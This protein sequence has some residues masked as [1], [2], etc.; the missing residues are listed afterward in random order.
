MINNRAARTVVALTVIVFL[1][2]CQGTT[3]A[4]EYKYYF[5]ETTGANQYIIE[6]GKEYWIR[7]DE[8]NSNKNALESLYALK[9]NVLY[10][11]SE[12]KIIIVGMFDKKKGMFP[13]H[14]PGRAMP[15]P[16]NR[17]GLFRL[18]EWYLKAPF[19]YWDAN[20]EIIPLDIKIKIKQKLDKDD[21]EMDI[22]N[23]ER[24]N[25]FND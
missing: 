18:E 19:E 12:G 5:M 1:G 14:A 15:P 6:D 10:P 9:W 7:F 8:E 24:Y 3:A 11:N 25:R 21:F 4:K 2:A 13:P 23:P 17:T 16:D 20:E 22:D